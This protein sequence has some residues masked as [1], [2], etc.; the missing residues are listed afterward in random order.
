ME[1]RP[2]S[3]ASSFAVGSRRPGG[4]KAKWVPES[5]WT[6]WKRGKPPLWRRSKT[7]RQN[8]MENVV[9]WFSEMTVMMVVFYVMKQ[10]LKPWDRYFWWTK[11]LSL[12]EACSQIFPVI[13]PCIP[14]WYTKDVMRFVNTSSVLQCVYIKVVSVS[15]IFFYYYLFIYLSIY[16]QKD[17]KW[18]ENLSGYGTCLKDLSICRKPFLIKIN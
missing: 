17:P 16:I 11:A 9:V 12:Y 15:L 6:L 3:R 18:L 4:W 8:L 14:S 5:I 7:C 10:H 13:L 1:V 2:I